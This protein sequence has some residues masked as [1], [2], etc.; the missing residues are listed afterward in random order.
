M[1]TRGETFAGASRPVV[2]MITM[3]ASLP[4]GGG[5]VRTAGLAVK[6]LSETVCVA[7]AGTGYVRISL[8]SVGISLRFATFDKVVS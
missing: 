4:V 5:G 1:P 6:S 2:P 3:P 7:P 8:G